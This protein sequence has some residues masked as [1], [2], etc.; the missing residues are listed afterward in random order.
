[1]GPLSNVMMSLNDLSLKLSH[2]SG[3]VDDNFMQA[4]VLFNKSLVLLLL[5]LELI[6]HVLHS[7]LVKIT[8]DGHVL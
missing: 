8:V 2:Q 5:K 3:L 7:N 4:G 6:A 1:M